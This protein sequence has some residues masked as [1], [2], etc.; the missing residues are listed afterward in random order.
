M[1]T[2]VTVGISVYNNEKT[3]KY[4]INSI[5]N[6]SYTNWELIIIDDGSTD[7]SLEIIRSYKDERIKVFTDGKNK[8]LITRLNQMI[9]L[10]QTDFFFRMDSDDIMHPE[11]IRKQVDFL[12]ENKEIDIVGA[13]AIVVD[14]DNVISGIRKN[15]NIV[16]SKRF[17]F[18]NSVFIHPTVAGKT[19]WFKQ[20]M[21][22]NGFHRC[23]DFE[24]WCRTIEFSN[25][26]HINEPL[27]FYRDPKN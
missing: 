9:N 23:E 1:Q 4:A 11:R 27:L 15:K 21:Y 2:K 12:I 17:V 26:A 7:N 16:K 18:E 6:Q 13:E 8:G 14:E 10:C 25:F 3:I 19:Q 24:L 22:N 20:N 5:L